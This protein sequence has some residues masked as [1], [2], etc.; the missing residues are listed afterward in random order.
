[1]KHADHLQALFELGEIHEDEAWLDSPAYGL[2]EADVPALLELIAD[3]SLHN[4]DYDSNEIWV[5]HHAWRAL[6]Q[7]GSVRSVEPLLMLLEDCLAEDIWAAEELPVVMGM[8]GVDAI[9][10]LADYLNDR[11]HS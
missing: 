6:G 2:S 9:A 5:P 10:P 7:L 1:M 11:S 3:R 8:I 4:A